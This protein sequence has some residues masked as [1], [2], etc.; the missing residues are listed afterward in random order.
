MSRYTE[1][2]RPPRP[3]NVVSFSSKIASPVFTTLQG[4]RQQ[5]LGMFCSSTSPFK[6]PE[7]LKCVVKQ[8]FSSDFLPTCH[9]RAQNPT[10]VYKSNYLSKREGARSLHNPS[11]ALSTPMTRTVYTSIRSS[12]AFTLGVV[13]S[14]AVS[15]SLRS[16]VPNYMTLYQTVLLA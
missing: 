15:L 9:A 3:K 8:C 5:V 10:R 11:G 7:R 4:R 1:P 2:V 12:M 14:P 16:L 6:S 13:P